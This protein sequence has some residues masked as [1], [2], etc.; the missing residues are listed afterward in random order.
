MGITVS[1]NSSNQTTEFF[2]LHGFL[3]F[4]EVAS[5]FFSL[6]RSARVTKA[7]VEN[8]RSAYD[9]ITER[10]VLVPCNGSITQGVVLEDA[11]RVVIDRI[12]EVYRGESLALNGQLEDG[13]NRELICFNVVENSE[14]I[15]PGFGPSQKLA[16]DILHRYL[17]DRPAFISYSRDRRW[18]GAVLYSLQRN[19]CKREQSTHSSESFS[20]SEIE[21]EPIFRGYLS[22]D[23]LKFRV[24][25]DDRIERTFR[26][27]VA[28][29]G[30]MVFVLPYDPSSQKVLLI[31]QFRP[32]KFMRENGPALCV[33]PIAGRCDREESF[34]DTA[35]REALEE[36]GVKIQRLHELPGY[37]SSPGLST[38]HVVGFIAE[39]NLAGAGGTY[40][41]KWEG[42]VT[43]AQSLSLEDAL[44]LVADGGVETG[45]GMI[46]LLYLARHEN[47]IRSMWVANDSKK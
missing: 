11:P 27:S 8:F 12:K 44:Q 42:E 3:A 21:K 6:D 38:E 29:W 28:S 26:R 15:D 23:D 36:A 45:H 31:E 33:G 17:F 18:K 10:L 5:R 2:F 34:A 16:I 25:G 35:K 19:S 40:G 30:D 22:V 37:Y 43:T 1:N 47:Q 24:E 20:N 32:G 9:Q 13:R 41:V 4:K 46:A 39:A 7:T 14:D